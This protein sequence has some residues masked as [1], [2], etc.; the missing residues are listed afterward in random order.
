MSP[1]HSVSQHFSAKDNSINNKDN[2]EE[3]KSSSLTKSSFY[4]L[5]SIGN[6]LVLDE[7]SSQSRFCVAILCDLIIKLIVYHRKIFVAPNSIVLFS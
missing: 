2:N 5:Y 1:S 6:E 3:K 7:E 4:L